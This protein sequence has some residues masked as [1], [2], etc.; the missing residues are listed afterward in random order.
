MSDDFN[1]LNEVLMDS[2]WARYGE[3]IKAN[4]KP[5]AAAQAASDAIESK[6]VALNPVLNGIG[7]GDKETTTK[8]F[9]V[10]DEYFAFLINTAKEQGK[11]E[12]TYIRPLIRQ[13][14]A[15][16]KK[17]E[18]WKSQWGYWLRNNYKKEDYKKYLN[19]VNPKSWSLLGLPD[20]K[21]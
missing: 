10:R 9:D 21:P 16:K 14:V 5:D 13:E 19:R 18:K 12:H 2:F 7:A 4:Y 15:Y 3:F 11:P 20:L 1:H 8:W 17:L 6:L